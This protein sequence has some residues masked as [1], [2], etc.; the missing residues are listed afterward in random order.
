MSTAEGGN[1][2]ANLPRNHLRFQQTK[3]FQEGTFKMIRTYLITNTIISKEFGYYRKHKL[4]KV[5]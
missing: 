5:N 4:Q 1:Q 2:V 3:E